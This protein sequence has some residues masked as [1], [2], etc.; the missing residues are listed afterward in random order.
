ME[1]KRSKFNLQWVY[2]Y[3]IASWVKFEDTHWKWMYLLRNLKWNKKILRMYNCMQLP[4]M[5]EIFISLCLKQE[6]FLLVL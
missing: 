5:M 4:E 2:E 3:F 1:K 6:V